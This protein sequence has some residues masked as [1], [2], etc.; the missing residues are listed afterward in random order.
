MLI[1]IFGRIAAERFEDEQTNS[2]TISHYSLLKKLGARFH[3]DHL[4]DCFDFR[5]A[6]FTIHFHNKR[7]SDR[8]YFQIPILFKKHDLSIGIRN[9]G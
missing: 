6:Q 9:Y 5:F 7:L 4:R 2:I 8:K 3:P 1:K